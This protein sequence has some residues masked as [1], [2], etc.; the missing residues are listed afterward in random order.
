M[1]T[2]PSTTDVLDRKPPRRLAA[3][4][5][6]HSFSMLTTLF[7]PSAEEHGFPA[8]LVT[9]THK[10]PAR[11]LALRDVDSDSDDDLFV[12]DSDSEDT[13][14][15]TMT[16]EKGSLKTRATVKNRRMRRMK[17]KREAMKGHK[18]RS[19]STHYESS[20]DI[21]VLMGREGSSEQLGKARDG[22]KVE[23]TVIDLEATT[24]GPGKQTTILIE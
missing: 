7:G 3:T 9:D 10:D 21:A 5:A 13:E 16:R 15:A 24:T 6:L 22:K 8:V 4:K 2:I 18:D 11:Q 12:D 23:P 1:S 17:Q 14:E 20:N 19:K